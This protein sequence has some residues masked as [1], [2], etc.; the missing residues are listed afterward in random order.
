MLKLEPKEPKLDCKYLLAEAETKERYR[1]PIFAF[2]P[3]IDHLSRDRVFRMSDDGKYLVRI[4]LR[5]SE[6]PEYES[7]AEA[8]GPFEQAEL[9]LTL[10]GVSMKEGLPPYFR[11]NGTKPVR[12]WMLEGHRPPGRRRRTG[13]DRAGHQMKIELASY[14]GTYPAL[15]C[16]R[17]AVKADGKEISF[18]SAAGADAGY[19]A[20][21]AAG[22]S[23]GFVDRAG[24]EP[25]AAEGGR[26]LEACRKSYPEKIR[27][28]LPKPLDVMNES[29]RRGRRGGRI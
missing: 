24:W 28:L 7:A 5:H 21:W 9:T 1:A 19:P 11:R 6:I 18:E 8:F 14:S 27:D 17:L 23:A 20:F 22:G 29:V 15:C 13:R 26:Q 10:N 12:G 2:D 16:G 25:A 4:I 3:V